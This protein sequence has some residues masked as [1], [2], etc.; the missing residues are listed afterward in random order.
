MAITDDFMED[1]IKL[2]ASA[3][4]AQNQMLKAVKTQAV[5]E[6]LGALTKELEHQVIPNLPED[7]KM[8]HLLTYLRNKELQYTRNYL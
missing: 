8:E 1:R 7:R 4:D 2:E 5:I 3:Q 6:F